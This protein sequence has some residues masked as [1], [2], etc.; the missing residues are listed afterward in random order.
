VWTRTGSATELV[1]KRAAP[2]PPARARVLVLLVV[3]GAAIVAA[4]LWP[5]VP[6]DPGY[7]DFA[8]T[9]ALWGVPSFLNVASN[10]VFLIVGIAGLRWVARQPLA[11]RGPLQTRWERGAALVLFSGVTLTAFG[12]AWYHLA[13]SNATLIWD[14]LPMTLA[15]MA[16]FALVIAD[17]IGLGPARVLLPLLLVVGVGSVAYWAFTE[18]MGAGDLRLYGLVQFLPIVLIPLL[19]VLFPST[20]TSAAGVLGA[21]AW[22]S[23][24]K[25]AELLDQGIFGLG[26]L[27]SGHTLKHVFAGVAAWWILRTLA[28]RRVVVPGV[29]AV[30]GGAGA[31]ATRMSPDQAGR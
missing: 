2:V 28:H 31:P 5:A 13:P 29:E 1:V 3:T 17:R 23:G 6:Q 7:H 27:V 30:P 18:R 8:D 11:E 14:R 9:R 12:S 15:F 21:L 10:V 25:V 4:A 19:L 22:Y 20:Y 24:A 26:G 16:F